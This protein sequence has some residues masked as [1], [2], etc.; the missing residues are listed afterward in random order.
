MQAQLSLEYNATMK[1]LLR[2]A[3]SCSCLILT[4]LFLGSWFRSYFCV[5][6]LVRESSHPYLSLYSLRGV[7]PIQLIAWEETTRHPI[8]YQFRTINNPE[9][10]K[11][12]HPRT[13]GF[14]FEK[15][16]WGANKT[17]TLSCI[18]HWF[19]V[20]LFGFL[21]VATRPNPRWRYSTYEALL[22]VTLFTLAIGAW[23]VF[24]QSIGVP[25][26]T[27]LFS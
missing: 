14:C 25:I 19:C 4:M 12:K 5:D 11:S 9:Q 3:I 1:K 27:P 23:S 6:Y 26:E 10:V 22:V 15:K 17:W 16:D 13:L 8:S 18:P 21:A 20:M 2:Q 7:V 24:T